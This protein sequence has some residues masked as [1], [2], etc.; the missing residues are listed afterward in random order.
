MM[1]SK[2]FGNGFMTPL[3]LIVS[4]DC[5]SKIIADVLLHCVNTLEC[6]RPAVQT[7]AFVK[8]VILNV[9][10]LIEYMRLAQLGASYSYNPYTGIH[11]FL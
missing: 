4:H 5:F 11:S 7:S 3:R 9:D 1:A 8:V 6:I 2:Q 10:Q